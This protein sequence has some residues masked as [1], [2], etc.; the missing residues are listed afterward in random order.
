M[1]EKYC[2]RCRETKPTSAFS[3]NKFGRDGLHSLCKDCKNLRGR[4]KWRGD[5][6][7]EDTLTHNGQTL[8][9]R[10]CSV[11][12]A[13]YPAHA[14]FFSPAKRGRFGLS[15]ECKPCVNERAKQR[16]RLPSVRNRIN[17]RF[18]KRYAEEPALRIR[19]RISVAMRRSLAGAKGQRKWQSLVGYSTDELKAH[20]ERQ[21]TNGMSWDRFLAGEIEIDHILPVASFSYKTEDDPEFRACWAL[22]NLRPMWASGNRR[23]RHARLHLI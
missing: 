7:P 14:D 20:L 9:A 22:P 16:Q 11:C 2:H 6:P 23:K 15:G 13:V 4:L 12:S 17:E 8:S 10:K 1:S 18:R 5:L 19:F 3:P 21:F